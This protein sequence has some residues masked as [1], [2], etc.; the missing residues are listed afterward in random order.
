MRRNRTDERLA[1]ER[2]DS[3]STR[4]R[5]KTTSYITLLP[6]HMGCDLC[7]YCIQL[8]VRIYLGGRDS[9]GELSNAK[10]FSVDFHKRDPAL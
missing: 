8:C 3:R 1:I 6:A 2:P 5:S 4:A 7:N 10:Y 9:E